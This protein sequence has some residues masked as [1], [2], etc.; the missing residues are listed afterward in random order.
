MDYLM[1]GVNPDPSFQQA[2]P[3]FA[4]PA[5]EAPQ[6]MSNEAFQAPQQM[7]TE[8]FQAPQQMSTEAFQAPQQMSTEA[9]QAAQ[10]MSTEAA[11]QAPQQLPTEVKVEGQDGDWAP[12]K[13][14]PRASKPRAPCWYW[15]H[16]C[17]DKGDRC[18]Y[19]HNGPSGIQGVVELPQAAEPCWYFQK[20]CCTKGMKCPFQHGPG[21]AV[22]LGTGITFKRRI[23]ESMQNQ[24]QIQ[25]MFALSGLLGPNGPAGYEEMNVP[26]E[27]ASPLRG[28]NDENLQLLQQ[29]TGCHVRIQAGFLTEEGLQRIGF[30]G[31]DTQRAHAK[32]LIDAQVQAQVSGTPVREPTNDMIYT[33]VKVALGA[34]DVDKHETPNEVVKL[35][36]KITKYARDAGQGLDFSQYGYKGPTVQQHIKEIVENFFGNLCNNYSDRPWLGATDFMLVLEAAVR[37]IM[38]ES[39]LNSLEPDELESVIFDSHDIALEVNRFQPF[40][41]DI[42]RPLIDGVKTKKKVSK[43]VEDGRKHATTEPDIGSGFER[44]E[45]FIRTW[46]FKFMELLSEEAG[47]DPEDICE[48]PKYLEVFSALFNHQSS[49]G[50]SSALPARWAAEAGIPENGWEP[51]L[52]AILESALAAVREQQIAKEHEALLASQAKAAEGG[53][54]S[55]GVYGR[56]AGAG[57]ASA[58]RSS[59]YTPVGDS[60]RAAKG[61]DYRAA[62]S[63][64]G[65]RAPPPQGKGSNEGYRAPPPQGKGSNEGY[66]APPPQGGHS[67][68]VR[69]SGTYGREGGNAAAAGQNRG[70]GDDAGVMFNKGGGKGGKRGNLLL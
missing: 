34:V 44:A 27:S 46:L 2:A 32:S 63:N 19:A 23:I 22:T 30:Y 47:G 6:Q 36:A 18:I 11:F 5:M 48:L 39:K 21:G 24:A 59:P 55:R 60:Q 13:K 62:R 7:S 33:A 64:D 4:P 20:G 52:Q 53:R 45:N 26:V 61:G 15:E 9:F 12:K 25:Q 1:A 49:E 17:C 37:E 70:G 40:V 58:P 38:D 43:A 35:R 54:S 42:V 3:M 57:S 41:Y 68:F 16:G 14:K 10:Q 65:Y 56:H 31:L 51:L 28:T 8:A 50:L 67:A 69:R 66:R 29:V